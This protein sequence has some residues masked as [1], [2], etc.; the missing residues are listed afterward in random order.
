MTRAKEQQRAELAVA[1]ERVRSETD[2]AARRAADPVAFVHRYREP[3]DQ[4]LVA[5]AASAIAFGNVV[6]IRRSVEDALRRLGPS[7]ARALVDLETAQRLLR[8]FVHRLLRGDDVARLLWGARAVQLEH[9]SLGACFGAAYARTLDLRSSLAELCDA[10]RARGGL[11]RGGKRRGPA[12]ILADA[13]GASANKRLMLFLRWMIRPADGVD[14][15]LWDVP[16]AALVIPLDTHIQKL[17]RNVGLTD[18]RDASFRTAEEIT[19]ALAT[20]DPRD[21]VKYD[22]SLCHLGMVRGCPSR[23]DETRCRGCPVMPVCRHWRGRG[24]APPLTGAVLA[25]VGADEDV[26]PPRSRARRDLD[27]ARSGPRRR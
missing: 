2:V 22:F 19:R 6:S 15:G 13:R 5:L 20:L 24:A 11:T 23:R 9:G 12:H 7:P 10:I 1:L 26:T 16:A 25:T 18:R 4:E 14:L 17:A 27:R 8:G 21:P 3:L